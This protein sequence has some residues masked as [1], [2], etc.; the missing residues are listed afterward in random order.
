MRY[1]SF[2][3]LLLM[4]SAMAQPGPKPLSLAEAVM[5]GLENNFAIQLADLQANVAERSNYWG[6]T[7]ALPRLSLNGTA[8]FFRTDNP[9][10]FLAGRESVGASLG[11]DWTLFDGFRMFA[12]KTRLALLQKQTGGNAAVVV[13]NTLQAIVLSYYNVLV[14]EERLQVL[15]ET[16]DNSRERL[17]YEEFR[18][19]LGAVAT[20]DLL[21]FRNAVITDSI[22]VVTQELA[23]RNARRTLNLSLA[24]ETEQVYELTDALPTDFTAYELA[25]LERE[26]LKDNNNLQNQ[27]LTQQIRQQETR[28]AVAA[29]Y[30]TLSFSSSVGRSLGNVSLVD[31]RNVEAVASDLS[32]GL[33]LSYNLFDGLNNRRQQQIAQINEQI[34]ATETRELQQSLRNE[35]YT[36]FDNYETRRQILALQSENV[37]VARLNLELAGERFQSGLINSLDYRNIQVQYLSAQ[38][39]RL[40]ALRDLQES[41]TELIRLTGGLVRER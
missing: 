13:E 5:L 7:G 37:E 21:Q 1:L 36:T 41:E 17:E 18:R 24:V 34:A 29:F 23:L 11:L 4:S 19:D 22:N 3:F 10:S 16:L 2:L 30:P 28:Q 14:A 40:S 32:L 6:A 38:L 9:G 25:D 31:G 35:L 39:N 20:F 15:R 26:M 8:N 33:T 27:Y 12:T